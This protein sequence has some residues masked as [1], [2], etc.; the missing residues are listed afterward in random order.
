[1]K[2]ETIYILQVY[3]K[4]NSLYKIGYSS[5]FK[6]RLKT[7]QDVNPLV[8]TIDTFQ[9]T[10][11]KSFEQ[12]FHSKYIHLC[13]YKKEWYSEDILPYIYE[14]IQKHVEKSY[15]YDTV[16]FKDTV[17]KSKKG[18]ADYLFWANTKYPFLSDAIK[19]LGYDRIEEMEYNMARIKR[20]LIPF[21]HKDMK[22]NIKILL[23]EYKEIFIG[24]FI[25][26]ER[27]KEIF[28]EIYKQLDLSK[29]PK[30]T[31]YVLRHVTSDGIRTI[32]FSIISLF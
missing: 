20:A 32:V 30:S 24:G 17:V 5:N 28:G 6:N 21:S 13:Q 23:S 22:D 31:I 8:E 1:M 10:N 27:M 25:S 26:N 19:Y 15:L 29:V 12:Y 4:D 14:E 3:G 18:D 7:Y 11:A 16:S 9:I 2:I